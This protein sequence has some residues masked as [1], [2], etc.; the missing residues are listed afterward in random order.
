M[1]S[2]TLAIGRPTIA[3]SVFSRS[4]VTDIVL[5]TAGAA[6][7]ALAAQVVVPLQPVPIT[8]QT[9]AVLLVGV[10][11]GALRGVISLSLY[12][13]LGIVGLPVYSE[14]SS[15]W[16]VIVGPTG[17]YII[18]FIFAAGFAGWLAQREW[19]RKVLWSFLAFLSATAV[20]FVFGL[21]WLAV[22]LGSVG[23]PNDIQSVLIAG[24]YPFILGGVIKA[25]LGVAIIS[26]AWLVVASSKKRKDAA[27]Q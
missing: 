20:P 12:A 4:L 23:A 26:T 13:V 14:A 24:F 15:G 16:N 17:G 18:G 1:T 9:L 2:P 11:L 25:I 7:T 6:L 5:V 3:D 8:G 27:Q 22:F 19:D 10:S 21:P